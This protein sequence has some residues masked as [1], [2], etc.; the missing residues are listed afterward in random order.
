[1][2][3]TGLEVPDTPGVFALPCEN[4]P[5]QAQL[6]ALAYEELKHLARRARRGGHRSETL[7]T[8]A[9]V[10]E[11]FLKISVR[12][13]ARDKDP[14]YLRALAARAMRQI[15]IDRAR[16]RLSDKRGQ[17]M[18]N[19]T[20]SG[21]DAASDETPFDLV[22]VERALTELERLDVRLARVVELHVFAGMSMGEVA[23]VLAVTERT[24][25]RDWR[26]ARAF[27]IDHLS[28]VGAS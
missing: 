7:D 22:A 26:K 27:L 2:S 4:T 5:P 17:G 19:V 21:V 24:T 1:M 8:T 9:L 15:L 25:F 12:D 23:Q 28:S 13:E 6:F 11:A 3:Q 18:Q 14:A 16:R 20:L 10:H